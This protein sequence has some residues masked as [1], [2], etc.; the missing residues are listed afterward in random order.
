MSFED[1]IR[2]A[3][4]RRYRRSVLLGNG[5]SMDYDAKRFGYESLAQEAKLPGLT[6]GKQ[7]LFD[8]LDSSNFEVVIDRLKA[9]AVLHR[10]YGG[11]E[12]IAA[13]MEADATVVRHGLADVLADRHPANAHDL[14][15]DEVEHVRTFLSNFHRIFTLNYD[16][17]L[18]WAINRSELG[19]PVPQA[20]GFEWPSY[21]ERDRLVWKSNP[22][23]KSQRVFF[24]HGALHLFVDS[25]RV[26]KI[27]F[28][29]DGPLV[30]ELRARLDEGKYPLVV[31]EGKREE[32]EYRIDR[33]AYLRTAHRRFSEIKGALFVHGVSMSQN[34]DHVLEPIESDTSFVRVLYVGIHGDPGSGRA[35][36]L[37]Q[38][39]DQIR[40]RRKEAGGRSL[41]IR[42]YDASSAHEWR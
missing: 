10:L 41:R 7:D 26:R 40:E 1:A 39:A 11:H 33:S 42:F 29:A 20:D 15:G 12:D 14:T 8:R 24:L 30:S 19:P 31:T 35:R 32:K 6:V 17:L 18:Y 28:A 27:S 25:R 22:S 9:S 5:F 2:H 23:G 4:E 36:E 13:S 16:L 21:R 38:R 34:D 37:I 3:S